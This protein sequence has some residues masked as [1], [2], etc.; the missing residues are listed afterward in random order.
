MNKHIGD[1][2]KE[3]RKEKGMTQEELSDKSNISRSYLSDVE[4]GRYNP[5]ITFLKSISDSLSDGNAY[6]CKA[7]YLMFLIAL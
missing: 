2:I 6:E 7:I 4:N 3:I 5:S 1:L